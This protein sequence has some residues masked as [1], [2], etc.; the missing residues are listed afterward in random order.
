ML[1]IRSAVPEL[2]VIAA[3]SANH[4]AAL[5][6]P[7]SLVRLYVARDRDAA[8]RHAARRLRTRGR[9]A[10]VAVHDL[11]PLGNDFNDD[12]RRLGLATLRARLAGQLA[13]EDATRFAASDDFSPAQIE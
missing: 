13:P 10:G 11:V 9:G 4:L 6:F 5:E 8:G 12:L 1:A 3:L 7:P 2:P